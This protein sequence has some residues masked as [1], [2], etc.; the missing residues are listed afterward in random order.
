MPVKDPMASTQSPDGDSIDESPVANRVH[1]LGNDGITY[2]AS[3]QSPPI[4]RSSQERQ[5]DELLSQEFAWDKQHHRISLHQ[6]RGFFIS[7]EI[8]GELLTWKVRLSEGCRFSPRQRGPDKGL[9]RQAFIP[10]YSGFM[11]TQWRGE[12]SAIRLESAKNSGEALEKDT[13]MDR[14]ASASVGMGSIPLP[15]FAHKETS[16]S[17]RSGLILSKSRPD[18]P[19]PNPERRVD[20]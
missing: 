8:D 9:L 17:S 14:Q 18:W 1:I 2:E 4:P 6:Q 7:R 16:E 3:H 10:R 20:D 5:T 15:T 11:M 13:D 12:A 19:I